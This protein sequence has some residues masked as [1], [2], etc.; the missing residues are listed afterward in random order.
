MTR[1]KEKLQAESKG[2]PVRILLLEDNPSD[3]ELCWHKLESSEL[4][5]SIKNVGTPEQFK[6]EIGTDASAYDIVLGDYRLPNWTGLEAVRWLRSS[7]L[8][9]PF[10][11]VT[12]TLGDEL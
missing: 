12:G 5:F 9:I 1:F 2:P 10:I 6:L 8:L 11:L 3:A 7:G 4:D